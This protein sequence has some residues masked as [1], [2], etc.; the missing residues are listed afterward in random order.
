MSSKADKIK[1]DI[2]EVLDTPWDTRDGQ[3]VPDT[4]DVKLS[5]GAVL[6]DATYAYADMANSTGLAQSATKM[7]TAKIIRTYLNASSRILRDNGGEIRSFDGDRVMAIF[8]G[9]F[10]N[11]SAAKAALQINWAASQ[12]IRPAIASKWE[13]L[14]WTMGHR[15]GIDTG[16]AMIVR[17]GVRGSNDLVSVGGAP[18]MA[19]KLSEIQGGAP[20]Y[21]TDAVYRRLSSEAKYGGQNEDVLMWDDAGNVTFGGN[22]IEVWSST[23]TWMP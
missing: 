12:V 14:G 13:K 16:E 19:A 21:I 10:K 7:Q 8:I 3:V 20:I 15:V 9:D 6:L 4:G 1:E 17:G 22:T 23:W 18:N 2:A 11:S 5:D